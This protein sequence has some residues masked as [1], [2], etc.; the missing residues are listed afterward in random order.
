MKEPRRP[1][2]TGQLE[3]WKKGQ[4]LEAMQKKLDRLNGKSSPGDELSR[5]FHLGTVGHAGKPSARFNQR[6]DA[7]IERRAADAKAA[8]N[9]QLKINALRWTL[10]QPV[11]EKKPAAAAKPAR[12][13][14]GPTERERAI[15][16][17]VY[18]GKLEDEAPEDWTPAEVYAVRQKYR[19]GMPRKVPAEGTE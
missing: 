3:R 2:D 11:V 17:H 10:N 9:L 16:E 6:R 14:A 19:T 7:A 1:G 4:K 5:F 15:Y 13:K 18:Y 12:K 8:A